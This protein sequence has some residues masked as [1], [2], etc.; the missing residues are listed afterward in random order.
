MYIIFIQIVSV[1]HHLNAINYDVTVI[2][3]YF[4]LHFVIA[5]HSKWLLVIVTSPDEVV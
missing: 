2:M 3:L 5:L 4:S 1:A